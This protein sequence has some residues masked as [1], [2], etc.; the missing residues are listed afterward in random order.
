MVLKS[1]K[2]PYCGSE[3]LGWAVGRDL[4]DG[5]TVNVGTERYCTR[6]NN[7]FEPK[8]IPGI[9]LAK[10]KNKCF[11]CLGTTTLSDCSRCDRGYKTGPT[12]QAVKEYEEQC[13]WENEHSQRIS[14]RNP[15]KKPVK[16]CKK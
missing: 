8:E 13:Q 1:L 11:G 2:C 12:K 3:N 14:K 7:L 9:K 15:M 6:C 10:T 16:R 4:P 5:R